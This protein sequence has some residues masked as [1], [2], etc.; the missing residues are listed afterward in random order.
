ML[1]KPDGADIIKKDAPFS[2]K[3]LLEATPP[4]FAFNKGIRQWLGRKSAEGRKCPP[5]TLSYYFYSICVL[6]MKGALM[7]RF[8]IPRVSHCKSGCQRASRA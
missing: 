6:T 8:T 1:S 2:F 7:K 3:G 4:S 5:L